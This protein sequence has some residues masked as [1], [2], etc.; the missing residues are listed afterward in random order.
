[1]GLIKLTAVSFS[2][3][4]DKPVISGLDFELCNAERIALSGANGAGKS[5]ILKIM[6]GLLQPDGGVVEAFGRVRTKERDF[7]E[8]RSRAGL[9]F[10]DADDQ[11]FSPT[12]IEDVRFGPLNQ[13]LSQTNADIKAHQALQIVGL[14]GFEDRVAHKLSGGEKRLVALATVLA[15]EPEVLLLDEPT[16]GLDNK[17]MARLVG[18]LEDLPQAM[19]IISHDQ[20]FLKKLVTRRVNLVPT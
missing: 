20:N 14:S 4:P 1:M 6:V 18:I 13:G 19:V 10:Q 2:Y 9:L 12:V 15:M 17:T 7:Y 16:A 8:V 11:L 5:T 3:I